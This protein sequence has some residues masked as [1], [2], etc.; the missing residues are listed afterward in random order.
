MA[1]SLRSRLLQLT[2]PVRA[3]SP[4]GT[5]FAVQGRPGGPISPWCDC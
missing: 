3:W 1:L 2:I 5:A 4:R